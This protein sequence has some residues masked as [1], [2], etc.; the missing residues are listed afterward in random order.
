MQLFYEV[1]EY[2][3]PKSLTLKIIDIVHRSCLGVV[4]L[5]NI[6]RCKVYWYNMDKD[7]ENLVNTCPSCQ[8]LSKTQNPTPVQ[9]FRKLR[10]HK[11]QPTFTEIIS[12]HRFIFQVPNCRN[13]ED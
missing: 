10:G 3:P 11:W 12:S 5:K 8:Q 9:I 1:T 4:K 13:H 2:L 6:H 7:I